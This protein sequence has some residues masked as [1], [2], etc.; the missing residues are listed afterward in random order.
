VPALKRSGEDW[1]C[2]VLR[3]GRSPMTALATVVNPIAQT[4]HSMR[5][6][7]ERQAKLINRLKAEPGYLGATLRAQAM[8]ANKRFL[9]FIDQFEELYTNVAD[10]EERLAFTRCLTAAADD[11]TAPVRVV[12]SVRSDFLDR[13]AEHPQFLAELN[14]GLFFLLPPNRDGLRDA[15]VQ[16]AEMAGY[17]FEDPSMVEDM[18]DHLAQTPGALPLLQFTAAKLWDARDAARKVFSKQSYQAIGGIGGALASHADSVLNKLTP[19]AQAIVRAIF[20]RL[21]T[22]ERT[23]A[24]ISMKEIEELHQDPTEVKRIID[25]LAYAR[26]V[27]VQSMEGG[28]QSTVE[29]VHESLIHGWPTLKKWLDEGHEDSVF[30]EQLRQAAKQWQAKGHDSGLLWRGEIVDEAR[31]FRARYR[32]ELPWQQESFLRAVFDATDK[33]RRRRRLAFV[34]SIVFL[35]GLV[36][37]AAVALVVINKAR[38]EAEG[39]LD[40]AKT[41]EKS[42]KVA[43]GE[44]E[45]NLNEVIE[46][47]KQRAAEEESRRKAERETAVANAQVAESAEDLQKANAELMVALEDAEAEKEKAKTSERHA[48]EAQERAER[49][50]EKA[51]AAEKDALEAKE[52]AEKLRT[53]EKERADRLQKQLKGELIEDLNEP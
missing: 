37:A 3:P 32:G 15:L 19:N 38:G 28:G 25:Q 22:P 49:A 33:G 24:V 26:L 29:I 10:P 4:S 8:K 14:Q 23:R 53:K 30:M 34:A 17:H 43:Q 52:A 44:A 2:V 46:K 6:E 7:V 45:K 36:A 42:A 5:D 1:E 41:A 27:V 9:L 16:P 40:A 39:A 31:K 48:E 11:P 51:K 21:V 20:L 13:V 35:L 47:E 18:L 50:A 12:L